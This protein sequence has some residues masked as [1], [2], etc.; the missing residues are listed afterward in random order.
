MAEQIIRCK[1][2]AYWEDTWA[3]AREWNVCGLSRDTSERRVRAETNRGMT[4]QIETVGSYGCVLGRREAVDSVLHTHE[5]IVLRVEA[6][7]QAV[8]ELQR[9]HW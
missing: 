1:D 2:C 7:E 4:K 6:L 9:N 5:P 3:P 8:A